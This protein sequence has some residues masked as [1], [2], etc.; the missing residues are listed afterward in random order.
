MFVIFINFLISLLISCASLVVISL[1][2]IYSVLFLVLVF[3][4]SSFFLISFAIEFLSIIFIVIYVGAI[5]VLF[6]FVVMMLNV[7]LTYFNENLIRFVPVTFFVSSLFLFNFFF[8]LAFIFFN[9]TFLYSYTNW[10]EFG[11]SYT[12]VQLLGQIFYSQFILFFLFGGFLLLIAI[13]GPVSLALN[14]IKEKIYIW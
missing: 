2:P 12:N 7:K 11:L 8:L 9:L 5:A 4:F 10:I 13:I 6:L 3:I 1:N 14:Q